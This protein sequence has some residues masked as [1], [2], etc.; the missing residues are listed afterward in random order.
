[1]NSR[2]R[3]VAANE[4]SHFYSSGGKILQHQTSILGQNRYGKKFEND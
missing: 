3:G 2:V 1:M 4:D